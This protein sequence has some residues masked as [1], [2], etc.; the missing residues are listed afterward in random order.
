M[1]N[2]A[3]HLRKCNGVDDLLKHAPPIGYIMCYHA[4][5]S[6]SAFKGVCINTGEPKNWGALELDCL[7]IRGVAD[8]KI[9]TP[10]TCYHVSFGSC[11]TEC[12]H[13]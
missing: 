7:G 8:P 5:F 3:T 12:M 6:R 11:A 4:E 9:E 1:T 10:H 2:R 13:K